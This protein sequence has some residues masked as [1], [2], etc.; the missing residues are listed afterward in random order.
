VKSHEFGQHALALIGNGYSPLPIWPGEKKPGMRHADGSWGDMPKW[1]RWCT[2]GVSEHTV[3]AWLRMIGD[4]ET[5]VG[6]AC[7]RGLICIDIDLEEAV[8]PLLAIL[9][10]SPVQKREGRG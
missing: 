3:A 6:V 9:P 4:G 10:P 7:G 2:E 8:E 1:N 5:G